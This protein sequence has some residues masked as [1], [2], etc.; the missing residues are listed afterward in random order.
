[1]S[2]VSSGEY[3]NTLRIDYVNLNYNACDLFN[4][5]TVMHLFF[6]FYLLAFLLLNVVNKIGSDYFAV[7]G[8]FP[9]KA[10]SP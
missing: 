1:M 3:K 7:S 9:L 10:I 5:L 6:C 8:I 4:S 2:K